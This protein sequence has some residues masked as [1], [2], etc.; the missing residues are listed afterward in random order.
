M[1]KRSYTIVVT[2]LLTLLWSAS[3][4]AQDFQTKLLLDGYGITIN[5]NNGNVTSEIPASALDVETVFEANFDYKQVDPSWVYPTD[6]PDAM[7]YDN[8]PAFNVPG[9]GSGGA[10]LSLLES[11]T[12]GMNT[13]GAGHQ[14]TL[15]Y[16][17][18]DEFTVPAGETW[19]IDSL[20]F[21]AYQTN[22]GMASTIT[23]VYCQIWDGDPSAGGT[24]VWGDLTTN[25]LA[26]T[27]WSNI[28]RASETSPTSTA[29]PIMRNVAATSAL[30]LTEGTYWIDWSTDGSAS[31]GPWAPPIAILG[32]ATTGNALQY[33]TAWAPFLDSG[34]STPQGLPFE[35]WGSGGGGGPTAFWEDDFNDSTASAGKWLAAAWGDIC[36]WGWYTSATWVSGLTPAFPPTSTG[37]FAGVSSDACG[38]TQAVNAY[39]TGNVSLDLSLWTQVTVHFEGDMQV[40]SAP[41]PA[42][43]GAF[44][45][46]TDG[47]TTW[48]RVIE[49]SDNADR[50]AIDTT[51]DVSSIAAMQS[52]VRFR[53]YY[54]GDYSWHFAVDNFAIYVDGFIPV[55]LSSFTASV[56]DR[57]VTLNW[58]TATET[59]NQ[60]FEVER[61][62]GSGFEKI[63]YLPG[64]GTTTEPRSYTF[65]DAGLSSGSYIY[66]LKQIDLDGSFA[67]SEEIQVEVST[68]DVYALDQNYPNPFNPSTKITFSLAVDSKVSLRIFDAL[69]QEVTTLVNEDLTAGAYDYD[70]NAANINSGVYFYKI[71]AVGVNGVQFVDVKKMMFLK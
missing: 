40:F 35:I 22:S 54:Y 60:G 11:T 37:G 50:P 43:T 58:A 31:S 10:D 44:D 23:G 67:Y 18:A 66:R 7:L 33:T 59:N 27:Y 41:V 30:V 48:T 4:F 53:F 61:N 17:M 13:L 38:T 56:N 69:G 20:I 1:L 21:Y 5:N 29:R 9:G 57:D 68:P 55:E 39:L 52:D 51:F 42:D 45:M 12:L 70:F 19:T 3:L 65:T 15:G 46:S 62:I 36:D 26:N 2:V 6:G 71:E 25:R 14:F 32:Q 8:G 63:G 24:I 49:Y 16:R 28:Y 34:T 47:G 64:F